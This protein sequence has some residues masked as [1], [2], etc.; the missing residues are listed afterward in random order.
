MPS[1]DNSLAVIGSVTAATPDLETHTGRRFAEIVLSDGVVNL[2]FSYWAQGGLLP[3]CARQGSIVRVEG[4]ISSRKSSSGRFFTSLVADDIT[5]VDESPIISPPSAEPPPA[6]A[7][8]PVPVQIDLPTPDSGESFADFR[9]RTISES[10][11][12]F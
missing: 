7:A 5:P 9:K 11:L 12:P 8:H 10:G 4:H 6:P 3:P 2:C 1:L